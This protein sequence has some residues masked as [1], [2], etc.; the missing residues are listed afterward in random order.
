MA[1]KVKVGIISGSGLGDSLQKI[2][3]CNDVTSRESAK[4]DFGYPSS[5]LYHGCI[6]GVSIVL[7]S[8]H[9]PGHKI[10][11]TAINYRANI[12]ALRLAGC[13]HVLASTAC[14]SLTESIGRGQLVVP[15]SFLDRT[16]SRN[17]TF[18]DGTSASYSGVCHMPMEPAFD[19]KTSE[20]L[21]Q[22]AKKLGYN[23]RK[24]GTIVTIEGPRFSS[25][26]ESNALRLWGGHL[27][28]MTTCPEVCLAKEAGLLYA[29]V[30]MA[31]DYDCW[32][33]CEDNVNAADVIIVFKQNVHKVTDLLLEAVK[34]VGLV[35]WEHDI[36][37]LKDLIE[38]SN[39]SAKS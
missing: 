1:S 30:A 35:D 28:N 25:K 3:N 17:G 2:F 29:A 14:G 19:L 22:A 20:I 6:N 34:M 23:M 26:A 32:K 31:T 27:V 38:S 7:L 10:S 11:P 5:D 21:L 39:V 9:G 13:T 37:K 15:D 12:E 33:D 18:Y 24:G 36:L 16:N 8:R 4:N